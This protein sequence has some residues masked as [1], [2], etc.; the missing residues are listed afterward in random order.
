MSKGWNSSF[1]VKPVGPGTGAGIGTE[2]RSWRALESCPGIKQEC[3][4]VCVH[5]AYLGKTPAG[6]G[7]GCGWKGGED[8][9]E[10]ELGPLTEHPRLWPRAASPCVITWLTPTSRAGPISSFGDFLL[11]L[12]LWFPISFE[13]S[14][15]SHFSLLFLQPNISIF[16]SSSLL[17]PLSLLSLSC[18]H[19]LQIM[20]LSQA[21]PTLLHL[22]PPTLLSLPSLLLNSLYPLSSLHPFLPQHSF[23]IPVPRLS[24]SLHHLLLSHF[25]PSHSSFPVAAS[26]HNSC[27]LSRSLFVLRRAFGSLSPSDKFFFGSV[28]YHFP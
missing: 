21:H 3:M 18:F 20:F 16:L 7:G 24:L 19:L 1:C 5:K 23:S 17:S 14:L 11:P 15:S 25:F 28:L 6:W 8:L 10:R 2:I 13:P 26:Q 27:C 9:L 4:G 12:H 22:P